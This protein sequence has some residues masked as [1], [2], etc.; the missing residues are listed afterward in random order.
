MRLQDVMIEHYGD[1]KRLT[2]MPTGIWIES[3]RGD[4]GTMS[5]LKQKVEE[6]ERIWA[7][8][9]AD[10]KIRIEREKYENF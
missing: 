7:D 8:L 10:E 4:I 3:G 9:P 5:K 2:H 6:H 1:Y